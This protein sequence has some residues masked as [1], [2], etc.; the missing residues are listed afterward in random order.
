M[1]L[2]SLFGQPFNYFGN[3]QG[4]ILLVLYSRQMVPL[5]NFGLDDE[6]LVGKVHD[7]DEEA[8]NF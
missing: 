1:R 3:K 6:I 4:N 8:L 2:D 5:P 7:G